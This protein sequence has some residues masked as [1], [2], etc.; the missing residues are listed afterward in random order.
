MDEHV[1]FS[2]LGK[3]TYLKIFKKRCGTFPALLVAKRYPWVVFWNSG[4]PV[5]QTLFVGFL[6]RGWI[7]VVLHSLAL[8][9][10]CN[11]T[12]LISYVSNTSWPKK[13]HMCALVIA[14]S[15]Q[16]SWPLQIFCTFLDHDVLSLGSI[17]KAIAQVLEWCLHSGHGLWECF[18]RKGT[19][20]SELIANLYP[21]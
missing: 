3:F 11:L 16:W 20:T 13:Q 12:S 21:P 19:P 10:C 14:R 15:F 7:I 4:Q 1:P 8:G 18:Q 2:H 6:Q 9:T 5:L 17:S